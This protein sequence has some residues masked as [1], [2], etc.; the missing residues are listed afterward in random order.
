[1]KN[2]K[3]TSQMGYKMKTADKN[4]RRKNKIDLCFETKDTMTVYPDAP[5]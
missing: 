1:M 2:N 3:T 5:K 4:E